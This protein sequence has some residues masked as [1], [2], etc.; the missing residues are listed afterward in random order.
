[1]PVLHV[2]MQTDERE[3]LRMSSPC[4]GLCSLRVTESHVNVLAGSGDQQFLV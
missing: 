1:M 3:T 4:Q 2:R